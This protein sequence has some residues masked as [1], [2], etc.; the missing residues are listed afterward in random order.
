MSYHDR[1]FG[2]TIKDANILA[3]SLSLT[4]KLRQ[5][6]INSSQI[7][8]V[9]CITLCSGIKENPALQTLGNW[10]YKII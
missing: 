2:M 3:A 7:D 4:P 1:L 8:D 9:L 5:L 10:Q 6:V